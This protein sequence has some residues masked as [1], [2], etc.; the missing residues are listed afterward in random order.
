M[1][2]KNSGKRDIRETQAWWKWED[3]GR[4]E[5]RDTYS[6]CHIYSSLLFSVI[7]SDE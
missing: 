7:C 4:G 1:L 5:K 3:N 2:E 6:L